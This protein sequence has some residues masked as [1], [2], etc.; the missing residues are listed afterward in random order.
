MQLQ[1][2]VGPLGRATRIRR[3]TYAGRPPAHRRAR[4]LPPPLRPSGTPTVPC[5][6]SPDGR[7]R[8]PR[9]QAPPPRRED[10]RGEPPCARPD[11]TSMRTPL[12]FR[13]SSRETKFRNTSGPLAGMSTPPDLEDEIGLT[14]APAVGGNSGGFG[15]ASSSP[16]GSLAS[17]TPDRGDLR[18]GQPALADE[19]HRSRFPNATAAV[20]RRR[21]ARDQRAPLGDVLVRDSENGAASPAEAQYAVGVDDRRTCSAKVTPSIRASLWRG[22]RAALARTTADR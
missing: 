22:V 4:P 5:R 14:E 19:P 17:P 6:Q 1:Q 11:G 8:I 18:V 10:V 9:G 20:A 3:G 12:V 21:D 16:R 15:H 7:R 13:Q 2:E